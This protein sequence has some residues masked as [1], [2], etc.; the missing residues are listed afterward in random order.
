MD[1]VIQSVFTG[2]K[3]KDCFILKQYFTFKYQYQIKSEN[4]AFK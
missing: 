1:R 2:S 4:F 3:K